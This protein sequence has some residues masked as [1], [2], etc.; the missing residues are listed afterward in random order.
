[1]MR[2]MVLFAGQLLP[3]FFAAILLLL[4]DHELLARLGDYRLARFGVLFRTPLAAMMEQ[5][6]EHLARAAGTVLF[7]GATV[8]S[9][10]GLPAH[11]R[12]GSGA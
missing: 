8:G 11:G 5:G 2:E 10:L 1:M 7:L 12:D 3:F 9:R 4:T 6:S